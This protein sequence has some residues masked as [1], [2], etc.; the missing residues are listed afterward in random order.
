MKQG[1]KA[2][3]YVFAWDAVTKEANDAHLTIDQSLS[4]DLANGFR[5]NPIE[6]AALAM[7]KVKHSQLFL[8]ICGHKSNLQAPWLASMPGFDEC[9]QDLIQD[10]AIP[11]FYWNGQY[12]FRVHSRND[13]PED[14]EY[15][16]QD[17]GSLIGTFTNEVNEEEFLRV[18]GDP[19][20]Y[21][22]YS[23][24]PHQSEIVLKK[25]GHPLSVIQAFI[26]LDET[27]SKERP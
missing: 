12:C 15:A 5:S 6:S 1:F 25:R 18:Q 4:F 14:C 17:F 23:A 16:I 19:I 8:S 11:F 13:F 26:E 7:I 24:I 9:G 2:Q 10:G 27:Q 20:R 3:S 21:V 22:D